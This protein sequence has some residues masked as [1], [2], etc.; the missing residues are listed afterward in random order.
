MSKH[1]K[2]TKLTVSIGGY[3]TAGKRDINQDA[4][5]VKDPYSSLEKNTKG[6]VACVA[7][8]VSCS[9]HGQ[10]ASQTSVTQFITD[11]Y[12]TNKSWDVKQSA[13]KVLNSLNTWLYQHNKD[14]LRHNGLITTFSGIILKSNTAHIVHAGDSRIYRYREQ[15]LTQLTRD[16]KRVVYGKNAI[17]T[18][19]LGMDC[20]LDID[21]QTNQLQ[22]GDLFILCSDGVHEYLDCS[23]LAVYAST[24]SEDAGV[25]ECEQL[26]QRICEDALLLG[27]Q[28]NISCLL[29]R[30]DSL[31]SADLSELFAHLQYQ[32]IPPALEAGHSIDDFKIDKVLHQGAR[33]HVYLATQ[34]ASKKQ[35]VLKMPSLNFADDLD[36]LQGFYKEQWV[37]QMLNHK[38][39]MSIAP[40]IQGSNF[41]Y[42]ICEFVEGI[43]LRQWMQENPSPDSQ[44]VINI[45][46]KTVAAVR[47][48]QRAGMVHRD[49]K[50]ENIMLCEDGNIKLIDFGTVRI[51]GFE[52]IIQ[53]QHEVPLGAVDYIAPEYLI[54]GQSSVLSDLFSIAVICYEMLCGHLP[55]PNNQGQS[56]DRAKQ[57]TW[58]YQS[59][60]NYR[61]ELSRHFD[62]LFKKALSDKLSERHSSMSEFVADLQRAP[63]NRLAVEEKLPLLQRDPA[64]FWRYCSFTFMGIAIAELLLLIAR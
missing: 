37:G 61:P 3:S 60:Q 28:D 49:L 18:R 27:S 34:Q 12:S 62:Q 5:A 9:E 14:D 13:S 8:G 39:I 54:D 50:P 45:I 25:K 6:V 59:I 31:P 19:A 20:H 15:K 55:Y 53:E 26:A 40:A 56:M 63:Q 42:H 32:V 52:E 38:Q 1:P 35:V 33:S 17:L 51:N 44:E 23:A 41:L 36:Y 11:Y 43:T 21:Y 46:E 29:V 7:D 22:L 58:Q 16:H 30:I 24:L 4:F 2:P 47:V 48:L 57:F 64:R 10:Q